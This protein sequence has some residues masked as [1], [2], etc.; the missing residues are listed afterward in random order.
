LVL[1]AAARQEKRDERNALTIHDLN[2]GLQAILAR[3]ENLNDDISRLDKDP[4]VKLKLPAKAKLLLRDCLRMRQLTWNLSGSLHEYCF[5]MHRLDMLVQ[6][7]AE[8][9]QYEADGKRV[10]IRIP[11]QEPLV[12][13]MSR[14]HLSQAINNLVHNAVKYS[15]RGRDDRPRYVGITYVRE[16]E[17][18]IISI[19]NY[20]VGILEDE[21]E[22]VFDRGYQGKLTEN[23][24][25]SGSGIGLF[26]TNEI[27]RAHRGEI[28][29][30]SIPTSGT[31]YVTS[32]S[33][34]LPYRHT[35]GGGQS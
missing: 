13:E 14:D 30:T 6:E 5:D 26:I 12:V 9:Y 21:I 2:I 11:S 28:S 16:S 33:V 17:S 19:E 20:G 22:R 24:Y 1:R 31:A 29:I 4:L 35:T 3:T 23:E 10:Q 27:V 8:L 7:A 32:V 34:R 15:F 25:R 18:C